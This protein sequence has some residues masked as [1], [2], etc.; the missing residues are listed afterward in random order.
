LRRRPAPTPAELAF[1]APR[2]EC[3]EWPAPPRPY[4]RFGPRRHRASFF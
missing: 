1:Q 2:E 3:R 4:E